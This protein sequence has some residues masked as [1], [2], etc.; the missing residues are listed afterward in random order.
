MIKVFIALYL[1]GFILA[2]LF[3]VPLYCILILK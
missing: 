1:I 2:F 3:I